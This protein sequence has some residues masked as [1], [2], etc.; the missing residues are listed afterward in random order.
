VPERP[1]REGLRG[2]L[3]ADVQER[4]IVSEDGID[5]FS[6]QQ[7]ET[8]RSLIKGKR[9]HWSFIMQWFRI[10]SGLLAGVLAV[11]N[12]QG[13]QSANPDP[14]A[15]KQV[16]TEKPAKFEGQWIVVSG[17]VDGDAQDMK[18]DKVH[19][20]KGKLTIE[21]QNGEKQEGTYEADTSKK[22]GHIDV[23]PTQGKDKDK[24]FKGI[25][26]LEGNQLTICLARP[27]DDRPTAAASKEGSG[28]IL[29]VLEPT[30]S[31]RK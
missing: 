17:T 23:T 21:E 26:I 2:F 20:A 7:S 8:R 31:E 3:G 24:L 29:L 13:D 6:L 22:P 28:H 10:A 11:V 14:I 9:Q 25:L 15:A 4:V 1:T 27:G 12:A 5:S 16:K 30:K 19:L 18:G